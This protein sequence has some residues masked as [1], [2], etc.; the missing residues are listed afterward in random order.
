M[1]IVRRTAVIFVAAVIT[2][3]VLGYGLA[4]YRAWVRDTLHGPEARTE[5]VERP[6]GFSTESG[7]AMVSVHTLV[8]IAE[9]LAVTPGDLLDGL[10]VDLFDKGTTSER[11]AG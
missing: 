4:Y 8:R 6:C 9:A 11:R 7:R 1:G 3:G 5:L 2:G 10:T